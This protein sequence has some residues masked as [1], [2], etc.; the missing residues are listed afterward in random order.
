MTV[1]RTGDWAKA[2]R[3]LTAAPLRL[4]RAVDRSLRQEA[5]HLRAEVVRGITRQAP[6]GESLE[7]PS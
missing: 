2:R 7:P 5:E 4:Q 1:R 3:L 6:G